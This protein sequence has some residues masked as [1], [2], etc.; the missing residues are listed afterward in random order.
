M[1]LVC[2]PV[3]ALALLAVVARPAGA[4]GFPWK[5]YARKPD[6][7]FRNDEAERKAWIQH[8]NQKGLD[9]LEALLGTVAAEFKLDGPFSF[10]ATLTAADLFVVPQIAS[11]RRFGVDL[12]KYTRL[13][14]VEKAA[15]STEHAR[16]ALPENQPGAPAA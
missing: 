1:K 11:G 7:W 9:A 16:R 5:T 13:L 8:F 4:E 10:G 3:A 15:L 12:T 6:A 14:G 2:T